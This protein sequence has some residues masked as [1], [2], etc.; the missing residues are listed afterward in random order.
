MPRCVCRAYGCNTPI[1]ERYLMCRKHWR[2][3]PAVLQAAIY[4]TM[5][6]RGYLPS[7]EYAQTVRACI[8]EVKRTEY[9]HT[10]A[11]EEGSQ[12]AADQ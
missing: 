3:I 1:D 8:L 11:V 2:M 7:L 10:F 5:P 4:A 9:P 12:D 6:K